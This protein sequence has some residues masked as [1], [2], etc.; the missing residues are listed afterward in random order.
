MAVGRHAG[1]GRHHAGRHAL[2]RYDPGLRRRRQ[3]WLSAVAG[4]VAAMVLSGTLS[5]AKAADLPVAGPSNTPS[6]V[7]AAALPPA[8]APLPT[9]PVP[10]GLPENLE[11]LSPYLPQVSCHPSATPGAVALGDLLRATYPGTSYGIGRDCG[12]DGMTS[13][14]YEGRAVDWFV[15][16]RK[17]DQAARATAVLNWLFA[18][19]AAGNRYAN[20][21]RLGVM[22]IIWNNKIWG[23]YSADAGWRAYSTCALR[24]DPGADTTCHRDHIHI[25]LSWAGAM[26]R[27]SFWTR[28]VAATDYGPCAPADLNWAAGYTAAR[29]TPCPVHPTVAAPAGASSALAALVRYSG[30]NLGPGSGGVIVRAV[31]AGLGLTPDGGY[32]PA[33]ASAV[34][35]VQRARGLPG[36]GSL[37]AASWRA[38]IA[39]RI[40]RESLVKPPTTG[41]S[42]GTQSTGGGSA[43]AP[44]TGSVAATLRPYSGTVLHPGSSGAAVLALQRALHVPGANGYFGK[45]TTAA[46]V[47]YQKAHRLTPDGVV[48]PATWKVL[49]G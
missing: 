7:L 31:Q 35:A 15:S 33:T 2:N 34:S 10:T 49:I 23:S 39:A 11:S 26:K 25:S 21:R 6:A 18:P 14:H 27:T 4:G 12:A 8:E 3:A 45:A 43:G 16:V 9:P 47:A 44:L 46:V 29:A 5:D 42:S 41:S 32:G 19:D 22:Y 20:A 13:E 40:A 1:A 28:T 48:G 30:A 24:P 17:P 37:D 36:T 38:L